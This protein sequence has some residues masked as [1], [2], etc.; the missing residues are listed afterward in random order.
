MKLRR[1]MAAAA[2]TAAIAPLALLAAPAAFADG[3]DTLI[4]D[5]STSPPATTSAPGGDET[6]TSAPPTTSAPD[7]GE[8]PTK[9]AGSSDTTPPPPPTS[10]APDPG[11]PEPTRTDD[12]SDEP[13]GDPSDDDDPEECVDANS[14]VK[15]SVKGLPGK[16]AKDSGW[17]KFTLNYRNTSDAVLNRVDF[18]TGLVGGEDADTMITTQQIALQTYEG[19]AWKT[20]SFEG[21]SADFVGH[22]TDLKPDAE[23]EVSLRLKVTATARTGSAF[24]VGAGYWVD[25]EAECQGYSATA[26]EFKIV[27]AGTPTSG[28]KPQEAGK[29]ALPV[30]RTQASPGVSATPS[31]AP[32]AGS[33][34]STGS[35]SALPMLG[36]VG[37][38]AVVAGG[39]VVFALRRRASGDAA[40]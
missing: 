3:A 34:A 38:V 24:S 18:F 31:A 10:D 36:L 6:P 35:N 29:V 23:A 15:V 9:P 20:V 25:P 28:T 27:A 30:K 14:A 11:S 19:K 26:Y 5:T 40:V 21:D 32:V 8:T 1:V 13:S 16:I 17:H 2:T 12:A 39:G 4:T 33:L 37:G 7:G 22:A